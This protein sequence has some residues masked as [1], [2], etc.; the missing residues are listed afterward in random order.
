MQC[1]LN[2]IVTSALSKALA[3]ICNCM[4]WLLAIDS[5]ESGV[6]IAVNRCKTDA[7]LDRRV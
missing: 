2:G 6:C 4:L 7:L 5:T 3:D 1:V